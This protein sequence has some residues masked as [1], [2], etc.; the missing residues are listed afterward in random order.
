[1]ENEQTDPGILDPETNPG[2]SLSSLLRSKTFWIILII[3]VIIGMFLLYS[4]MRSR[5]SQPDILPTDLQVSIAPSLVPATQTSTIRPTMSPTPPMS[6]IQVS[7]RPAKRLPKSILLSDGSQSVELTLQSIGFV[8]EGRYKDWALVRS[9][10]PFRRSKGGEDTSLQY[11]RFLL[12]YTDLVYLPLASDPAHVMG[13]VLEQQRSAGSAKPFPEDITDAFTQAGYQLTVDERITVPNLD[14][15]SNLSGPDGSKFIY[16]NEGEGIPDKTLLIEAFTQAD[17]TPIW[18]TKSGRGPTAYF[19]T[20]EDPTR[21]ASP[22]IGCRGSRCFTSN[23]FYRFRPD[24]TFTIYAYQLPFDPNKIQWNALYTDSQTAEFSS[25]TRIGCGPLHADVISI[26]PPDTLSQ[27][28][29]TPIGTF[30]N[31]TGLVYGLTDTNHSFLKQ[32]YA[33]YS[34]EVPLWWRTKEFPIGTYEAFVAHNPIFFFR[35]PFDRLIRL[36]NT[37]YIP[38]DTCES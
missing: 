19:Y 25:T 23:G 2:F 36:T 6:N 14:Y 21:T 16:T 20:G 7:Y 35:D 9:E 22:A 29:L 30:N 10:Q 15:P 28:D 31:G 5:T 32:F 24:G 3:L 12:H 8:Q 11:L 27:S 38:P 17:G 18:T 34:G 33:A 4:G 37:R 13:R 26:A 1:M